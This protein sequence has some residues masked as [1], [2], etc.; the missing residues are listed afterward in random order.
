VSVPGTI[1][2]L[3][4]DR[5][6]SNHARHYLGWTRNLD[7][8]LA[9]HES[10]NGARLLRAASQAGITWRLVR[11][12]NGDRHLERRLKRIHGARLCPECGKAIHERRM[13]RQQERRTR[14][15]EVGVR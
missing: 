8:R 15:R 3:C 6:L 10:G 9:E 1:Y 4:F 13:A 2:L 5:P 12:W 14:K 7:S 11:T